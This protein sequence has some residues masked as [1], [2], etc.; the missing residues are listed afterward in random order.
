MADKEINS[1]PAAS[2]LDGS[3]L[4]HVVQ[5]GNSRKATAQEIADLG[6]GGGSASYPDF[7]GNSGEFLRVNSTEDG[8][9]WS[10]VRGNPIFVNKHRRERSSS[11]FAVSADTETIIP[12]DGTYDTNFSLNDIVTP[13]N[14]LF[15][16]PPGTTRVIFDA[17]ISATT[18][19]NTAYRLSINLNGVPIQTHQGDTLDVGDQPVLGCT[20]TTGVI[21]VTAGD[22]FT[23]SVFAFV[24]GIFLDNLSS[25]YGTFAS[26]L[27]VTDVGRTARYTLPANEAIAADVFGALPISSA[28]F[29]D[30]G[31]TYDAENN[32]LIVPEGVTHLLISYGVR[33]T[34]TGAPA[35]LESF[36]YITSQGY[37]SSLSG[38]IADAATQELS[39][40]TTNV[41]EVATGN[42]IQLENY[43]YQASTVLAGRTFVSIVD[44]SNSNIRKASVIDSFGGTIAAGT[45]FKF[46]FPE[47]FFND[48]GDLLTARPKD[49][50]I[51]PPGMEWVQIGF[52]VEG[53]ST[54]NEGMRV[55]ILHSD[56]N[57]A[58]AVGAG[59]ANSS[60]AGYCASTGVLKV[61][62]GD[63]FTFRGE[64]LNAAFNW[65]TAKVDVL[66]LTGQIQ[67][68][69]TPYVEPRAKM[70][71]VFVSSS[72]FVSSVANQVVPFERVVYD[73]A[74]VAANSGISSGPVTSFSVPEAGVYRVEAYVECATTGPTTNTGDLLFTLS[75]FSLNFLNSGSTL[76]ERYYTIRHDPGVNAYFKAA[77]FSWTVFLEAGGTVSLTG[78]ISTV[79]T[80]ELTNNTELTITKI[81]S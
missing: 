64:P 71:K 36:L 73:T 50:F 29:D 27:D 61:T 62:P 28:V 60:F 12:F 1:L 41:V 53:N 5:G 2:T 32:G 30:I 3:E 26:I 34:T 39:A 47:T 15:V 9:E 35:Y 20:V 51:V 33:A 43:T 49:S 45:E 38:Q 37:G 67:N 77:T 4:V 17:G 59:M 65:F 46:S 57:D 40:S 78:D 10:P 74:G 68:E 24:N 80:F 23:V 58:V 56:G 7:T 44:V 19:A 8:V 76:E 63:V 54:A 22:V 81:G 14:T 52:C 66:D 48:V 11:S 21:E 79:A 31:F 75:V 42:L 16:V 69:I 70:T 72:G 6:G 25:E 18:L 13:D 55:W